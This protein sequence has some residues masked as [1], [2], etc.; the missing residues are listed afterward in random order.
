MKRLIPLLLLVALP[1]SA[2][3]LSWDE[4]AVR[5]RLDDRGRL[6]IREQQTIVFDGDWN[7]GERKF[8]LEP[9]QKLDF[10][11]MSRRDPDSGA[12]VPLTHGGLGN[13]HHFD[14]TDE[15]TLRWRSRLPEDPPFRNERITYVLDYTLSNIL[16]KRG[17]EYRLNHD[18]AFTDRDGVIRRF[19]LD[20]DLGTS[21][22]APD[23]RR[24]I[25]AGPLPPGEGVVVRG[26]LQYTGSG[27]P[28][29]QRNTA[30]IRLALAIILIAAPFLL[31]RRM[32]RHEESIGRLAPLVTQSISPQWI[33]ENL[34]TVPPEVIGTAWDEDA[35]AHEVSALLARW[36]AEN[37]ITATP[38][39]A[40]EL[41]M[42]LNVPRETFE[43]YELE[44]INKLFFKGNETSTT[45]IR[46]YYKSSGFSPSDIV[47]RHLVEKANALSHMNDPVAPPSRAP[48]LLLLATTVVCF[49]AAFSGGRAT[50]A[51]AAPIGIVGLFWM[52]GASLARTW[53][54]RIDQ[55]LRH[56]TG[57]KFCIAVTV[58][59]ALVIIIGSTS[60]AAVVGFLS[61]GLLVTNNV[62]N[63][64]RSKRGAAA[65]AFRKRLAAARQ[66]FIEELQ[67]PVP[68]MDDGWFP[69]VVA[70]GLDAQA[71]T[72]M[73]NFGGRSSSLSSMS[74]S[75]SSSSTSTSSG[76]T[77][78]GGA[79]G[80]AGASGSWSAAAAGLAAGVSSAS[81]SGGGG[82]G[83][84][85]SS[86]GGGGGGGW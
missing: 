9:G 80:G 27:A 26:D 38:V 25:E 42:T 4:L 30:P 83:G 44:L 77:G 1:A 60:W 62:I 7:G 34:L 20:L 13:L 63:I 39:S 49:I 17:G 72:W 41:Q 2:R 70:F 48:S 52:I 31:W 59:I 18:F 5:A 84:G 85:G 47:G 55:G 14:F 78:G 65:I 76:W 79:F 21:W 68:A 71:S 3:T 19:T 64:A 81:S 51:T 74:S 57:V 28:A 24:H 33:G 46:E 16:V 66:F 37:R 36:A 11:G 32:R 86:S 15:K 82:G 45:A 8:R 69:Y 75:S 67:K 56:T 10:H 53:R 43:G 73:Q 61:L 6:H 23:I 50:F 29:A 54:G 35:G 58:A 22:S 40:Q 12:L